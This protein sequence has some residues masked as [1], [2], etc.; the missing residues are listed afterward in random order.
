MAACAV[1]LCTS[2]RN[3]LVQPPMRPLTD[4]HACRAQ[5]PPALPS[6]STSEEPS[7]STGTAPDLPAKR[8]CFDKE[9]TT[10][11]SRS[12]AARLGLDHTPKSAPRCAGWLRKQRGVSN[13]KGLNA[14][15]TSSPLPP[16][17]YRKACFCK[18]SN[19]QARRA[20]DVCGKASMCVCSHN[21][22]A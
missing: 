3:P 22:N 18:A 19:S 4:P 7:T 21:C 11:T 20:V 14:G 13:G 17:I 10:P 5:Q 16:A 12:T 15:A 6:D 1:Q 8:L 2:R 9:N